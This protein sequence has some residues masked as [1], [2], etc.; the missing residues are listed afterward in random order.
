M[1]S[2]VFSELKFWLMVLVSV[3][4]PF[5]I[6]GVLLVKQAVSRVTVLLL[7]VALVALAGLDVYF[8]QRLAAASRISPSLSG[9]AFFNSEL[10]L[11]LYLLPA[12]FG[13]VGVNMI[14]HILVSHLLEAETRF[15][16][17]HAKD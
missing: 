8:L 7:G 3:V 5:G 9:D 2:S 16:R 12:M 13:G 4:L 15:A 1:S 11:A 17:R 6:Y 14:S 10:T